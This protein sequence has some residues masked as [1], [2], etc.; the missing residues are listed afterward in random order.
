[1]EVS[2]KT[3]ISKETN[4]KVTS[5][6]DSGVISVPL[7]NSGS[8]AASVQSSNRPK[9][10]SYDKYASESTDKNLMPC[11][12]GKQ[13]WGKTMAMGVAANQPVRMKS[14]ATRAKSGVQNLSVKTGFSIKADEAIQL[15]F[16]KQPEWYERED[17]ECTLT[18]DVYG[19]CKY[20][21]DVDW[22]VLTEGGSA[23][24]KG[25]S[26]TGVFH[27]ELDEDMQIEVPLSVKPKIAHNP[28]ESTADGA[29]GGGIDSFNM[30][31]WADGLEELVKQA[32]ID[33]KKTYMKLTFDGEVMHEGYPDGEHKD[34]KGVEHEQWNCP[35]S[36]MHKFKT[37]KSVKAEFLA[38]DAKGR[39]IAYLQES[40]DYIR[41]NFGFNPNMKVTSTLLLT[42][43]ASVRGKK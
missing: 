4:V 42:G 3:T 25:I 13:A 11:G 28:V 35:V 8:V 18:H 5:S 34:A 7:N 36:N 12:I 16:E 10:V 19:D 27:F 24:I 41:K 9:M 38:N 37:A 1:M 17:L 32:N 14:M 6:V 40:G 30:K 33:N 31:V 29:V 2:Q 23:T 21:Q 26:L 20:D 43:K 39:K 22:N 15:K